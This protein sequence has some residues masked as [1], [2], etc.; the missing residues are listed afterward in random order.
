MIVITG[1]KKNKSEAQKL[2][3]DPMHL[4]RWNERTKL[5]YGHF[6][7]FVSMKNILLFLTFS[8]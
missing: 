2:K 3:E 4:H 6:N 7:T 5:F 8:S 1:L